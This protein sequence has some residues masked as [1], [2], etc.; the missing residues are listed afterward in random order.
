MEIKKEETSKRQIP[1]FD[2]IECEIAWFMFSK[3]N[4]LRIFFYKLTTHGKFETV[5]LVAIVL[6]SIKLVYDTY[7]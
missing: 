6:S 5:V 1:L 4:K 3:E 2:G 7:I